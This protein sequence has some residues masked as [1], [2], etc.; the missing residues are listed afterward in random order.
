[1]LLYQSLVERKNFVTLEET[2]VLLSYEVKEAFCC[3]KGLYEMKNYKRGIS[4]IFLLY[5]KH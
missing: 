3:T 5:T 4:I 1:M 2:T